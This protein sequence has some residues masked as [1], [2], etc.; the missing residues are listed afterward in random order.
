MVNSIKHQPSHQILIVT[1]KIIDTTWFTRYRCFF[2]SSSAPQICTLAVTSLSLQGNVIVCAAHVITV[3]TLEPRVDVVH[4]QGSTNV[5]VIKA[6][7]ETDSQEDANVRQQNN[8]LNKWQHNHN[9]ND[10]K[11]SLI[12]NKWGDIKMFEVTLHSNGIHMNPISSQCH[13]SKIVLSLL[14]SKTIVANCL[15]LNCLYFPLWLSVVFSPS[16][17]P[18]GTYKSESSPGDMTTC[19]K[20]PDPNHISAPKSTS[21]KDCVCKR[22]YRPA[23]QHT[24]KGDHRPSFPFLFSHHRHRIVRR[25]TKP[26]HHSPFNKS[27][28]SSHLITN[29]SSPLSVCL[30]LF[31]IFCVVHLSLWKKRVKYGL[32][33]LT[34]RPSRACK[35][36]TSITCRGT[37]NFK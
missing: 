33:L 9:H 22:G 5:C 7:M 15:I 28:L 6:T 10:F 1:K 16:A 26:H 29:T 27:K 11:H 36:L 32:M 25:S 8:V 18:D 4:I 19:L 3:V 14:N 17:C 35:S 30:T 31:F 2:L 13:L 12:T 37:C 20:C 24:C 21:I 23:G 34:H